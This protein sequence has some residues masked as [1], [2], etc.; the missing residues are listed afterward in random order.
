MLREM[1]F[2]IDLTALLLREMGATISFISALLRGY[3]LHMRGLMLRRFLY[4]L[5]F[6]SSRRRLH[7]KYNFK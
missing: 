1:L 5:A 7:F 3:T 6:A 2:H 4:A